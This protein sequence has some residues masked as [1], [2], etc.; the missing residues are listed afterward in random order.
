MS[1][2]LVSYTAAGQRSESGSLLMLKDMEEGIHAEIEQMADLGAERVF[3][4]GISQHAVGAA[5]CR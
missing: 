4:A 1:P 5:A 3:V 2:G